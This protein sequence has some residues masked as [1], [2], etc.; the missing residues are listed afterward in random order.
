MD[1]ETPEVKS[2]SELGV[3]YGE[4]DIRGSRTVSRLWSTLK[5]LS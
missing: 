3:R 4:G 5:G 2:E 1:D